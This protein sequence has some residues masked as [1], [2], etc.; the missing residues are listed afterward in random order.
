MLMVRTDFIPWTSDQGPDPQP[1][2]ARKN[3]P[4]K[5]P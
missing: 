3:S 5:R 2:V 1:S 4:N